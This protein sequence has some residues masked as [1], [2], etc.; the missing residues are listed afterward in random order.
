MFRA[1][2]LFK[3]AIVIAIA[4]IV[5]SIFIPSATAAT[6]TFQWQ[7]AKGYTVKGVFE[8]ERRSPVISQKGAGQTENLQSLKVNFYDPA[9]KL[10]QT[11]NNVTDGLAKGNYF[12]FHF[13]PT[14]QKL[15]GNIDLGG[16]VAGETYLKGTV[17]CELSLIEVDSSGKEHIIDRDF[18]LAASSN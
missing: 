8:Y 9:N 14:T 15:M 13:D 7:G 3:L 2:N 6:Q 1:R 10:I 5:I 4:L 18:S 16:E 11:Y 17:E 12:E